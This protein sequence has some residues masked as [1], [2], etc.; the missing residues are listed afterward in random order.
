MTNE[1][2]LSKNGDSKNQIITIPIKIN[3]TNAG[4]YLFSFTIFNTWNN[5]TQNEKNVNLV[6]DLTSRKDYN[7]CISTFGL[8]L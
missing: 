8:F 4:I 1:P 7:I 5:P 6:V 2:I 3:N